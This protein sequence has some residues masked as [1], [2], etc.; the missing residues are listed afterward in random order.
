H[1][2]AAGDASLT[3]GVMG[4]TAFKDGKWL[5]FNGA[6]LN[7][8][9]DLQKI[10]PVAVVTASFLCDPNSGIFLPPS[11]SVYTSMDGRHFDLVGERPNEAGNIRGEPHLQK[12]RVPVGRKARYIRV[13]AKAFGQIP[14]GYLFKGSMSWLFADEIL[15]E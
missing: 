9:I 14:D 5:G 13:V 15:V 11:V 6:D 12:V 7:A 3:D 8:T 2:A 4:T 10:I 1:Y